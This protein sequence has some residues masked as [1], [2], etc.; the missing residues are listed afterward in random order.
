MKDDSISRLA[1][2]DIKNAYFDGYDN[3]YNAG[4]EAGQRDVILDNTQH[5]IGYFECGDALLKMWMDE[6]LT[7]GEYNRIMDRLNAHETKKR[8]ENENADN[9]R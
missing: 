6:V 3:G 8:M 4:F 1:T 5:E 9:R 2:V 7:D